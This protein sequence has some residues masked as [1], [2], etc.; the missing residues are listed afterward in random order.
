MHDN[1]KKFRS[2]RTR[3]HLFPLAATPYPYKSQDDNSNHNDDGYEV[4]YQYHIVSALHQKLVLP[5]SFFS[6]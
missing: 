1:R 6:W 3:R 5:K 2:L 4:T